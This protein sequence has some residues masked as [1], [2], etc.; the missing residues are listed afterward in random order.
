VICRSFSARA[1]W[2][3]GYPDQGLARNDEAVT[4]AQHIAHPYSLV[5]ALCAAAIFHQ[6]RREVCATQARAEA[7]MTLAKEQGLPFWMV[8]GSMLDGWALA[9]QGQ[10]QE[11]IERLHQGF[12]AFQATGSEF[13]RPY[14]LA[15]LAEAYGI[16]GQ[17]EAGL[18]VLTEALMRVDT[19]G[20]CWYTPELNRLKGELLLQQ[21][22]DNQGEAENCFHQAIAIA[23][24]QST[25]SLEL[26]AATSLA[27]LW[28]S[29]G[30][31]DEARQVLGDVYRWFTEGFDTAD[32]QDAKT[33]LDA[34]RE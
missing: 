11:G 12:L 17:P 26:R 18:P 28:Q 29:Q 33:L 15:L 2:L 23:Q 6:C 5:W 25:K 13:A 34:L 14:F 16:M 27:R 24:K 22:L 3:L 9:Q 19:T 30:N 7:A 4:L 21:S 10:V 31:R 20:E 1:L 8:F 32:L